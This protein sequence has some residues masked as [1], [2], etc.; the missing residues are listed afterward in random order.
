MSAKI[1]SMTVFADNAGL[2]KSKATKSGESHTYMSKKDYG[3]RFS[4]KGAELRKAHDHYRYEFGVS[5]N[6]AL[7]SALASGDIIAQRVADTK[8]GIS[9]NFVRK[10]VL[11]LEA[12]PVQIAGQLS[13]EQLLALIAARKAAPAAGAAAIEA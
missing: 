13:D 7:A 8:T 9:V 4:L 11:E 1:T 10:S 12:D 5:G 3:T 6:K 2:V